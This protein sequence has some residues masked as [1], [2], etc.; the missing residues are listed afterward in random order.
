MKGALTQG[1]SAISKDLVQANYVGEGLK[2]L[3]K[4]GRFQP[5]RRR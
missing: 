1:E 5:A 3:F 4:E 2:G